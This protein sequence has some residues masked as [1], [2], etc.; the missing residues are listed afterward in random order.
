MRRRFGDLLRAE[1]RETVVSE[2]EIDDEIQFLL[3]AVRA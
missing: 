2:R 1:I 3:E